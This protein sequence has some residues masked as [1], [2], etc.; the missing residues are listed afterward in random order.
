MII[1]ENKKKILDDK[2][3]ECDNYNND[4]KEMINKLDIK[5]CNKRFNPHTNINNI[6]VMYDVM[7]DIQEWKTE[8]GKIYKEALKYKEMTELLEATINELYNNEEK[9][10]LISDELKKAITEHGFKNIDEKKA[11]INKEINKEFDINEYLSKSNKHGIKAQYKLKQVDN[12]SNVIEGQ[13]DKY[14]RKISLLHEEIALGLLKP[15]DSK[16]VI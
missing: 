14:S 11:W 7:D 13:E 10:K 12:M 15:N 1:D 4:I 8:M 5:I 16:G 2:F 6:S 3:A 9:Q